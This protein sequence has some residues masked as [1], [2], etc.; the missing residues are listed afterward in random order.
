MQRNKHK[1]NV[2]F[3]AVPKARLNIIRDPDTHRIIHFNK[4]DHVI[5][6]AVY[7]PTKGFRRV[8]KEHGY[9][10]LIDLFNN[11]GINLGESN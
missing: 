8:R 9:K 5:G 7:H 3:K 10:T 2:K 1:T 11:I 6:N 4:M